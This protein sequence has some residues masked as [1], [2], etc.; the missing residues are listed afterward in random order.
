MSAMTQGATF[1]NV[2]RTFATTARRKSRDHFNL[3][4]RMRS[5][6]FFKEPPDRRV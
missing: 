3:T 4:F 5:H 6:W 2:C 1:G